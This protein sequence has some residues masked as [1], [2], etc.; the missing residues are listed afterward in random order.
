VKRRKNR[1][2]FFALWPDQGVRDALQA[3]QKV[4]LPE[5]VRPTHRDDLHLTLHFLGQ[6]DADRVDDLLV[7]GRNIH[8][9]RFELI[10]DHLGHFARPRVLWAGLESEPIAL[11]NL[12]EDLAEGLRD[13]R[14]ELESRPYR[15]HVTLARKVRTRPE[16]PDLHA[17][18]WQARR[19][20]LVESCPGQVP[21]YTPLQT[22]DLD[23]K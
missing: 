18:G 5:S 2:L 6:V 4:C 3:W 23:E 15:P 16:I 1:R 14:F 11:R 20:A 10:L 13:L 12:H 22:W 7:L 9:P 17:I 8:V 19:W 21:L